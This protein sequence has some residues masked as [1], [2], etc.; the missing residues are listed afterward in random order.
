MKPRGIV[1]GQRCGPCTIWVKIERPKVHS[2]QGWTIS[3]PRVRGG[4]S[5]PPGLTEKVCKPTGAQI[6]AAIEASGQAVQAQI[7]YIAVDVNLL[8]ADLRVVAEHSVIT[9]QQM[10]GMQIDINALKA[11]VATLEAKMCRLE[12]KPVNLLLR[13]HLK[14]I[15]ASPR[16]KDSHQVHK[17]LDGLRLSRL[18]EAQTE[19]LEEDA[20]LEELQEA[21]GAM[22]Y[23][24]APGSDSL[25]VEFYHTYSASVL[26]RVLETLC[27][28]Q[29]EGT[30]PTHM[31][32][33]LIVMIQK[34]RKDP[35]DPGS[36]RPLSML[37][38]DRRSKQTHHPPGSRSQGNVRH[39]RHPLL[40][41]S[42]VWETHPSKHRAATK[43]SGS[44]ALFL[45]N[46]T[47]PKLPHPRPG[48]GIRGGNRREWLW[49]TPV[50]N[51]SRPRSCSKIRENSSKQVSRSNKKERLGGAFPAKQRHPEAAP[52][53]PRTGIRGGNRREWLWGTPVSGRRHARSRH[54][55]SPNNRK[56]RLGHAFSTQRRPNLPHSRPDGDPRQR[57]ALQVAATTT[58]PWSHLATAISSGEIS[59]FP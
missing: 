59:Q 39:P 49:G 11:T 42:K 24:K 25:P 38:V 10:N 53:L 51:R 40:G 22:P 12:G 20:T 27:E 58:S 13:D 9:E 4:A 47:A 17:Y 16:R 19:E 50:T 35:V 26:P 18:A 3:R 29:R 32:K 31:R 15:Y 54:N 55:P 14:N 23:G 45:L 43:R 57:K 33:A 44:A 2:R 41:L 52:H 37:N 46:S 36:Y 7:A 5:E 30:L 21:L 1:R 56:E 8:R 34:P 6:L 28:A 48:W